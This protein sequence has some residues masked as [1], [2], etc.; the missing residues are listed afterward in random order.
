MPTADV[1]T[2]LLDQF[3]D[4]QFEALQQMAEAAP[5]GSQEPQEGA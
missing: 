2:R 4:Q 5:A 1:L 3:D